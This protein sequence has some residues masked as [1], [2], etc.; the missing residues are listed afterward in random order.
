MHFFLT[1]RKLLLKSK[2]IIIVMP[3]LILFNDVK[4]E[5]S[6]IKCLIFEIFSESFY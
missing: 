1:M 5:K 2:I 3:N 6:E 4:I